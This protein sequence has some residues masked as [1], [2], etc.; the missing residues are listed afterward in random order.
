MNG[1]KSEHLFWNIN[2]ITLDDGWILSSAFH[3]GPQVH[4]SL[5]PLAI[6]IKAKNFNLFWLGKF[7]EASRN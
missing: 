7:S 6:G 3:N 5:F 1:L 2:D 4:Q